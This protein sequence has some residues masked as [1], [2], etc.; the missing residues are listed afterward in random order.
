MNIAFGSILVYLNR[1][2]LRVKH[3]GGFLPDIVLFT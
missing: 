1:D 3:N 2:Y